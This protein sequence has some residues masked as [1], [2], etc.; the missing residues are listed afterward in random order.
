MLM[1]SCVM[2]SIADTGV[3]TNSPDGHTPA[4][5]SLETTKLPVP[6]NNAN[7]A[8]A[9]LSADV[10]TP[11][12]T[13]PKDSLNFSPHT[14]ISS[15]T[16]KITTTASTTSPTPTTT[17]NTTTTTSA[18]TTPAPVTPLPP[19]S[20]GKWMLKDK[21]NTVCIIVQMAAQLNISYTS[22]NNVVST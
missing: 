8:Q 3:L 2:F 14:T 12:S 21:N 9:N 18:P 19:P 10:K 6:A 13:D 7:D 4:T 11:P 20:T 5:I 17:A 1:Q 16:P 15:T 22:A